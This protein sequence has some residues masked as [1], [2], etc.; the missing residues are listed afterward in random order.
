MESKY[1]HL[2]L[3][4]RDEVIELFKNGII[5]PASSIQFTGSVTS[6]PQKKKV[7]EKVF[8][9]VTSIEYSINFF[10]FFL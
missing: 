9:K 7:V 8:S 3:V 6:L 1:K 2:A 5:Y 4:R 10:F